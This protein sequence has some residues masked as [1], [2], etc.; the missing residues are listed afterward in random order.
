[1]PN[2]AAMATKLALAQI[3]VGADKRANLAV[4]EARARE[5]AA[6][7]ARL[8]VFPEASMHCFG[9]PSLP[10]GPVAEAVGGPFTTT[11]QALAR[12]TRVWILAGMFECAEDDARA[13]NTLVLVDD[14]GDVRGTYR[15]IH[16]YDAFG[17]RESDRLVAGD[18]GTLLFEIDGVRFGALTCYDLRFP[19]QARHLVRLGAQA[20]VVPAA[21]LAGPLKEMQFETL[22]RARAIENTAY[23]G[24]ADQCTPGFCGRSV[25][26]DPLGVVV[27]SLG[28]QEGLVV[29]EIDLER[30]TRARSTNPS[31]RNVREDAYAQW[32]RTEV[33][34]AP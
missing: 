5:A 13:Y 21:W 15:K 11:L 3:A 10:L 17:Y 27:G 16:L 29:G 2:G 26:Y 19:E 7:G 4:V 34:P 28:E 31:L 24:S 1:V 25:L 23:V 14:A 30:L 20:I 18:G 22:L 12:E 8:V 9:D 32:T 33:D 6:A